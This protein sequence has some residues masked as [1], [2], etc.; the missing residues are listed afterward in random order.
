LGGIDRTKAA[1]AAAARREA[2]LV[3]DLQDLKAN[4]ARVQTENEM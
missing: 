1:V 3:Q 4:Y 2:L